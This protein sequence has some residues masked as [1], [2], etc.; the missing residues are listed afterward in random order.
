MKSTLSTCGTSCLTGISTVPSRATLGSP[1]AWVDD[2]VLLL[3]SSDRERLAENPVGLIPEIF[4]VEVTLRPEGDRTLCPLHGVYFER[5][6]SIVV[7]AT[8]SRGRM[9]FSALHELGHHLVDASGMGIDLLDH[10]KPR[11]LEEAICDAFAAAILLPAELVD[12]HIPPEGPR[13]ADVIGL[14]AASHAS[15]AATCVAAALRMPG[16]GY[17]MLTDLAARTRF[18]AANGFQF[19]VAP[20]TD[21]GQ[22]SLPAKAV[23]HEGRSRGSSPIRFATGNHSDAYE[24]DAMVDG[25]YV[26]AVFYLADAPWVDLNM[27][28]P[29]TR[30][31]AERPCPKCGEPFVAWDDTICGTCGSGRCPHCAECGC[32]PSAALQSVTCSSCFTQRSAHLVDASGVCVDCH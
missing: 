12:E 19:W 9:R 21:Q 24:G 17:V 15:R 3:D 7:V 26:F 18:T 16:P 10:D 29:V 27:I 23:R 32:V 6:N 11:E 25:E 28:E 22:D 5:S 31:R 14:W 8:A 30:R 1:Q 20:D 2:L 13:A 4:G